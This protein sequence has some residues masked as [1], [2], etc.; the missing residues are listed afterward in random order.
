MYKIK[1]KIKKIPKIKVSSRKT[2]VKN[3]DKYCSEYIR[4]RDKKCC[5][6]GSTERLTN[7]HLFSRTSYNTRWYELNCHC[8]C[9]S[10]NM[11]HEFNP[12][13]YTKW[14]ID[15]YGYEKYNELFE[16]HNLIVK[17]KAFDLI[18]IADEYKEKLEKITKYT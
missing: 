15:K 17:Y 1:S 9:S 8:Q 12:H 6:C 14:F 5:I 10:C 11:I 3:A 18:R 4:A 16:R 13:I 2:L 7:G